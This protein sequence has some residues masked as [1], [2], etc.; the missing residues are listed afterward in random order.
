MSP[1]TWAP[2]ASSNSRR[3]M[4]FFWAPH[5]R[6]AG[7]SQSPLRGESA[8][9][10][11]SSLLSFLPSFL[12]APS[13]TPGSRTKALCTQPLPLAAVSEPRPYEN[14]MGERVEGKGVG[15]PRGPAPP[16]S[17]SPFPSAGLLAGRWHTLPPA[18]PNWTPRLGPGALKGGH[19]GVGDRGRAGKGPPCPMVL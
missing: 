3:H 4:D 9:A 14:H 10:P 6:Q 8:G 12:L 1:G 13:P 11:A 5:F 7:G 15:R 19:T 17:I 18:P 2:V 16:A